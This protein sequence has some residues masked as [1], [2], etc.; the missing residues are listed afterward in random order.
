MGRLVEARVFALRTPADVGAYTR[1]FTPELFAG[2]AVLCADHSPVNIY[3]PA[4][5]DLLIELFRTMN[6][7]WAR[8]A[9]VVSRTNATLAMQLQRIV[10]ES[11]NESRRVFYEAAEAEGFLAP[12]LDAGEQARLTAFLREPLGAPKSTR[13][14]R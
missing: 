7:R 5:A 9:I 1:E 4:V 8:V 6:S 13:G 10:R 3:P 11:R 14:P 12:A 2:G